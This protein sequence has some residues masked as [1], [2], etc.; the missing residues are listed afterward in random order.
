MELYISPIV[1]ETDQEKEF[2]KWYD[3]NHHMTKHL[4]ML[5]YTAIN[6][7]KQQTIQDNDDI[8]EKEKLKLTLEAQAKYSKDIEDYKQKLLEEYMPYKSRCE[9][10]EK[11]MLIE[12]M[13]IQQDLLQ[14][15]QRYKVLYEHMLTKTNHQ[16]I[17]ED[18]I[19]GLQQE[20][21]IMKKTNIAKGNK[22][23]HLTISYLRSKFPTYEFIDRSKDKH[24]CDIHMIY[25]NKDFIA[26]ECKYKDVIIRQDVDKFYNDLDRM[27][28][29]KMTCVAGLFISMC[30][31]NIPH[32]GDTKI[33]FYKNIPVIFVGF[34]DESEFDVWC[35]QYVVLLLELVSYQQQSSQSQ[36]H[37]N[38]VMKSLMPIFESMK[39]V[40]TNIDKLK[41]TCSSLHAQLMDMENEIKDMFD[42]M[43]LILKNEKH[44]CDVCGLEYKTKT[45]L[46]NHKKNK[47][48]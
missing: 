44:K 21:A 20:I 28:S 3:N 34:T 33:E 6:S 7:A 39:K 30:S 47:H 29:S 15:V 8:L 5:G 17:Y 45:G 37:I 46:V 27:V 26:I 2:A 42:K 25:P 24:S 43:S 19:S 23:E 32:I 41:T 4:L 11:D 16:K 40:K 31:N 12:K 13:R 22:G 9:N 18:K 48:T 38:D 10:H 36:E 35:Y 14:E 1:I